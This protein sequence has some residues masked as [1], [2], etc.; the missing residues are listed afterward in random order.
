MK[1]LRRSKIGER[2]GHCWQLRKPWSKSC[3]N[4]RLF[5]CVHFP[6]L[7]FCFFIKYISSICSKYF[8]SSRFTLFWVVIIRCARFLVQQNFG[9]VGFL[10]VCCSL[11]YLVLI[12]CCWPSSWVFCIQKFLFSQY[13]SLTGLLQKL[14]IIVLL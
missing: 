3:S 2:E 10:I 7:F 14:I 8:V 4:T 1:N 13:T 6:F 12:M 11:T 9:A 5:V